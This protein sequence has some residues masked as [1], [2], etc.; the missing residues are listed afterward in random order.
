MVV[1]EGTEQENTTGMDTN[2]KAC[3]GDGH[4]VTKYRIQR[5]AKGRLGN[6]LKKMFRCFLWRRFCD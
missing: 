6:T 1:E 3:C 2:Q 5:T 4:K